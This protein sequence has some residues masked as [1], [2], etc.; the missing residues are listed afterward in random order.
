MTRTFLMTVDTELSNFPRPQG[1]FGRVEGEDWGLTRMLDEFDA[2]GL[3]AT[4]FLDVYA[5][6]QDSADLALQQQAAE[7]IVARRIVIVVVHT[8]EERIARLPREPEGAHRED[9]V[10]GPHG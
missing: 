9:G 3:P 1:I 4:F 5:G 8:E 6:E 7:L 10:G 2:L